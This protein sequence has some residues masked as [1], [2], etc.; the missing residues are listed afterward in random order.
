MKKVLFG[1]TA[2]VAAGLMANGAVAAE[3]IQMGLGGYFAA[4]FV[5]GSEDDNATTG[6]PGANRRSHKVSREA[7]IFFK[8]Q[9]TLDN[10][11]KVGVQVELEAETCGDQI[12]ESYIY[13]DG[14]YGRLV[15]G[16]ENSAP[17]LMSYAAPAPSSGQHGV[18]SPNFRHLQLGTNAGATLQAGSGAPSTQVN[19]SNDSEKLTYFTPRIAGF[20][21]GISYTPDNCEEATTGGVGVGCGGSYAGFQ[22]DNTAGQ[23]SEIVEIGA[24]YV[25]KFGDVGV[26]VSG[27]YG[28]GNL[29]ANNAGATLEDRTLW[30]AG[31]QFSYQGFTLGGSYL[32]D[33]GGARGTNATDDST[34]WNVGLRYAWGPWGVGIA[35]ANAQTDNNAIGGVGGGDD[36]IDVTE[37][38]GSYNLGPGISLE[39]GVQFW[40][41][42]DNL[43]AAGAE[44]NATIFFVGTVLSF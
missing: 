19:L 20:Q 29:E 18:N 24:N 44:N 32:H 13:F 30:S 40:D 5:A 28:H 4:F 15:L 37:V 17:Y 3:K 25:N 16:A 38:G 39:G 27:G 12:D 21:F 1:T 31:A 23:W 33:D 34:Q 6:E 14:A 10:G 22:P 2:L 35:Y 43:N 8:G 42:K 26:A 36:E 9:T 11:I 7:E 41:V